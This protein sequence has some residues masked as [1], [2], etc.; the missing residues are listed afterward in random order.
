[1]NAAFDKLIEHLDQR[2]VRYLMNAE[3]RSICAD[4]SGSVGTYRV[5]A[6][7]EADGTLFQVLG[8]LPISI[9]EGARPSIAETI[10]RANFGLRMG[11]FEMDVDNGELRFSVSQF[12]TDRGLEDEVIG[13]MMGLTLAM[14]DT[15]LPAILSVVYGNELP[16]DAIRCVEAV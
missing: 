1:M 12:L 10:A 14:L 6:V 9:P 7:V 13:H 8:A 16:K 3:L 2:Q 5:I 11:K 4:F 15:Y